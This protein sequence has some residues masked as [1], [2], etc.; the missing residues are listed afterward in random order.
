MANKIVKA[1]YSALKKFNQK[2][3]K[4]DIFERDIMTINPME[5]LFT[6]GQDIVFSDTNFKFSVRTD[7]DTPKKHVKNS[8]IKT[9]EGNET[10]LLSDV[11][12]SPVSSETEIRI[13]PN[14]NSIKDFAYYGSAIELIKGTI[15]HIIQYFP[16]ELYFSDDKF[17]YDENYYLIPNNLEVNVDVDFIDANKVNNPY[18]YFCLHA[19]DYDVC[20]GDTVISEGVT[21]DNF[22][23][24]V[25]YDCGDGIIG[26]V[27]L[28]TG[29]GD[30]ILTVYMYKNVKYLLYQDNSF[31][32]YSLRP[33]KEIIN[34][35]YSSIDDFESILINRSTKPVYKAIFE[36]PY[37][38]DEGNRYSMESYIFPNINE[39]NPDTESGAYSNYINALINL[40]TFHDE[41]DSDIL[42]RVLTHEAI[43]NLDWTF[44]RNN[45]DTL[46]ELDNI[47]TS[48][49]Q[50]ILQI[51]G[52]QFDGLKRYIDN[53]KY[54]NNITYNEKNNLPNYLLTDAV[55]NGGFDAILPNQT[56]KTDI[57]SDRL[58]SARTYGYSE[59]DANVCFMKILKINE[60]YLNSI[61]GTRNGIET[62][63][64][65]LGIKENEYQLREYVTVAN[66]GAEKCDF[67]DDISFG[68]YFYPRAENVI[69]PSFKDVVSI[70]VNKENKTIDDY[71]TFTEGI[72]VKPFRKMTNTN[73]ESPTYYAIPW[74]ENGKHYDGDWY[75]Q[76]KGGWG[77]TR[78]KKVNNPV[79]E[80]G[81]STL[82]DFS[83]YDETESYL[84][85]A[86]TINDMLGFFP[87][88]VFKGS[89]CYVTDIS[90]WSGS[91]GAN[92]SHYFILK[93]VDKITNIDNSGTTSNADG[94]RNIPISEIRQANTEDGK[95]VVYL[96]NIIESTLGNNP[97]ISNGEYDDGVDYLKNLNQIFRY[98]LLL[99]ING[100]NR[101]S[102][103]DK[104][105][106]KNSYVFNIETDSKK[107]IKDDWKCDYFYNPQVSS[108]TLEIDGISVL[109]EKIKQGL[110]NN[111]TNGIPKKEGALLNNGYA[112]NPEGGNINEEPS[113]NSIINIK[114]IQI[115]FIDKPIIEGKDTDII[116]ENWQDYITN[117][118]MNY[119]KQMLPS[120]TLFKWGFVSNINDELEDYEEPKYL[121]ITPISAN[122]SAE[123]TQTRFSIDTNIDFNNITVEIEDVNE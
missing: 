115:A 110:H 76:S 93:N 37:E 35:Y 3:D 23:Q 97:H 55:E 2:T 106:I 122:V 72:A 57:L 53:I 66:G 87:S 28:D 117:V 111:Y 33:S 91:S 100:L 98:H 43:K 16:A 63:L 34:E 81:V 64:R 96:E 40:G 68:E 99:G 27:R 6:K 5:D 20:S 62:I 26:T 89:I 52:R 50:P 49:I 58:F 85:I 108:T 80:S 51:Y 22:I 11:D 82:T 112:V 30:V 86:N 75:F 92:A 121:I 79:V 113:A 78:N 114:N 69:Y 32:G 102:E 29:I 19:I 103:E 105:K 13:K 88:D 95:K 14:Y 25:D 56:G 90:S 70:N 1:D 109:D 83:I 21:R 107:F 46:E 120:T 31:I 77:K 118:V 17:K 123:E 74:Y 38:T 9:S 36:T 67:S 84:K 8:W 101:F 4:G 39:W 42:W 73:N 54:T 60:P 7:K 12:S 24:N 41:Y 59:V 116:K 61:K 44:I 15:N 48:R 65:L 104:E 119:V 10:W 47:D 94:W 18:R 71:D 45:N